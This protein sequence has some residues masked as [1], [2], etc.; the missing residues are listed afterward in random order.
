[1]KKK[2]RFS[3]TLI[4]A[5]P[6]EKPHFLRVFLKKAYMKIIITIAHPIR[7]RGAAW[8]TLISLKV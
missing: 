7:R 6:N 1:M 3:S 8:S 2:G 5:P 4:L